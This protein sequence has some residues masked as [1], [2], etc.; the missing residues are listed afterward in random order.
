MESQYSSQIVSIISSSE[1]QLYQI[2]QSQHDLMNAIAKAHS[3]CIPEQEVTE[4]KLMMDKVSMYNTKLSSIK[5]TMSMLT[6]RSKQLQTKADNL[7]TIKIQYLSQIDKIRKMEQE[8]DQTIA[9]VIP[10]ESSSSLLVSPTV[11][12]SSPKVKSIVKRKKTRAREAL[13]GDDKST[14]NWLPKKVSSQKEFF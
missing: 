13:I 11:S 9:A 5:A 2:K 8:K 7:K 12:V 4:I 14:G 10:N 1:E 6:G 3:T